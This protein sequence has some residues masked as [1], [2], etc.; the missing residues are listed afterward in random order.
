MLLRGVPGDWRV[1][2]G[3]PKRS[4]GARESGISGISAK[5]A[6]KVHD[7][8]SANTE[9]T[10]LQLMELRPRL[11]TV[12]LFQRQKRRELKGSKGKGSEVDIQ[13]GEPLEESPE[14]ILIQEQ[15]SIW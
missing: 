6:L 4:G 10:R 8:R 5:D 3:I 9:R 2:Q 11:C 1:L 15:S 14:Y 13:A 12:S 7:D